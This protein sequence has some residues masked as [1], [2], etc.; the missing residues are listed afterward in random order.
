MIVGSFGPYIADEEGWFDISSRDT[1]GN[2]RTAPADLDTL[3]LSLA[4][5]SGEL[6]DDV[7]F[8]VESPPDVGPGVLLPSSR[9][10][11]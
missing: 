10:V 3:K 9:T 6:F 11:Y 8:I 7:A 1:F 2:L 5:H 4:T